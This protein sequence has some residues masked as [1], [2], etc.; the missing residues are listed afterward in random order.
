MSDKEWD[1]DFREGWIADYRKILN[2]SMFRKPLL[3]HFFRYL[4]L[5]AAHEE[6]E[7]LP[8]Y[9]NVKL[10]P[11]QLI[12]GRHKA[13]AESGLT[14]QTIRT[15]LKNLK[16]SKKIT[17]QSTSHFSIITIVNWS[18]YQPPK[19][20]PNQQPNQPSNQPTNQPTN[21]IQE[22]KKEEKEKKEKTKDLCPSEEGQEGSSQKDFYLT[23]NKEKLTGKKLKEFNAFWKAWNYFTRHAVGKADAA[24][25]WLTL[26]LTDGQQTFTVNEVIKAAEQESNER[27]DAL[28]K[29]S[30]P[31]YP[32]KWL[33]DRRWEDYYEAPETEDIPFG[34]PFPEPAHIEAVLEDSPK[35]AQAPQPGGSFYVYTDAPD[36]LEIT[37]DMKAYAKQEGFQ[38][39]LEYLTERFLD[40]HRAEGTQSKRWKVLWKTFLRKAAEQERI[41]DIPFD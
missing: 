25:A 1:E 33:R 26:H 31:I 18:I 24:D 29:G 12:F 13:I 20:G 39:D 21:H 5:K 35:I 7:A 30:T 4:N 23:K 15:C 38:G 36:N 10:M 19:K 14:E 32:A 22:V 37:A 6:T 40:H 3:S 34:E 11:G 16:A 17:I 2:N 27:V 9:G 28:D 41:D 8:K